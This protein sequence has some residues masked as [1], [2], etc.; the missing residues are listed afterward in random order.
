MHKDASRLWMIDE[1]WRWTRGTAQETNDW[2]SRLTLKN[3]WS[4]NEGVGA[5]NHR[6]RTTTTM[7]TQV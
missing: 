3:Q 1:R 4:S 7:K 2:A 5:E 6:R